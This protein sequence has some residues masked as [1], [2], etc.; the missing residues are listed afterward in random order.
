MHSS[1]T[2]N[3]N[4]AQDAEKITFITK[5]GVYHYKVMPFRL[6]NIGATYQRMMDLIFKDQINEN[7]ETYIND[8]VVQSS[9]MNQHV[10]NLLEVFIELE[11]HNMKLNPTR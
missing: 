11:K 8:M 9:T 4:K 2:T 5:Y 7:M 6:K 3:L 1:D 10:T